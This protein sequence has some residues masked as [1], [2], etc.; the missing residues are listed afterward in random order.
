VYG[1]PDPKPGNFAPHYATTHDFIAIVNK[2]SGRD[3][4][5]FFDVYLY[6]AA[7]PKL[8][9]QRQGDMLS[10]HWQTPHDRPFPMP[11][12]VQ[13]GDAL[14]VLSMDHGTG[15]L[16]VPAGALVIVDPHSKLLRDEPQV[17]EYQQWMKQQRANGKAKKN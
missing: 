7:L 14:H 3:L 2:V 8:D 6:E 13:V 10:L 1:R 5:W 15:S 16:A 9:V 4:S 11:V 17:T 12:E